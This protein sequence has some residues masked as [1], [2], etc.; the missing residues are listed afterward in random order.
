MHQLKISKGFY[1]KPQKQ[2]KAN[3]RRGPKADKSHCYKLKYL[4]QVLIV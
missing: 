1:E 3:T 4:A 2:K